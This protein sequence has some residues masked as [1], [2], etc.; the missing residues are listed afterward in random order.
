MLQATITKEEFGDIVAVVLGGGA[1][2]GG[3]MRTK[4]TLTLRVL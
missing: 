3:I 2:A 1:R 4:C